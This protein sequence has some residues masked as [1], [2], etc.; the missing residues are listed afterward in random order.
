MDLVKKPVAEKPIPTTLPRFIVIQTPI[1]KCIRFRIIGDSTP[2][3]GAFTTLSATNITGTG[4]GTFS[5]AYAGLGSFGVVEINSKP[6]LSSL[7]P[8]SSIL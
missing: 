8:S 5:S 6:S 4:I 1:I 2:S 7:S 3:T